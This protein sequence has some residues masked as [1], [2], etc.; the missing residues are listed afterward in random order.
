MSLGMTQKEEA[1]SGK[2]SFRNCGPWNRKGFY[3]QDQGKRLKD[4]KR[5]REVRYALI[6][7]KGELV[8]AYAMRRMD[9]ETGRKSQQGHQS[10]G[11]TGARSPTQ[12]Q[13]PTTENE[14]GLSKSS[15]IWGGQGKV[16]KL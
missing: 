9:S 11:G 5:G 2:L 8:Q 15:S 1:V 16:I 3:P 12:A 14:T 4:F 13:G 7:C 10:G 6:S